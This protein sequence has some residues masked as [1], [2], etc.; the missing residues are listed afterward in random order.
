MPF[1]R[2]FASALFAALLAGCAS[3]AES[4]APSASSAP[5]GIPGVVAREPCPTSAPEARPV[6][7]LVTLVTDRGTVRVRTQPG[8]RSAA[9]FVAL[10]RCGYYEQT[11]FYRLHAAY[12]IE[13]GDGRY[14]RSDF[15]DE[16]RIGSGDAGFRVPDGPPVASYGVGT[17]LLARSAE[18]DSGGSRFLVLLDERA[19]RD[20]AA[21]GWPFEPVGRISEGLE[22]LAA[23]AEMPNS[24]G[25]ADLPSEPVSIRESSAVDLP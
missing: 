25:D 4:V 3:P 18:P 10:A 20:I 16:I 19:G 9:A 6:A 5:V 21:S 1:P 15:I 17:V 22:V 12:D 23:I 24:G 14:G 13:G 11:V 2:P 8:S 7:S